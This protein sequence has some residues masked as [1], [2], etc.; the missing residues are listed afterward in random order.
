VRLLALIYLTLLLTLATLP[1][2]LAA[3]DWRDRCAAVPERANV[4]VF[5]PSPLDSIA[6]W[7]LPRWTPHLMIV[8]VVGLE[9][10][11]AEPNARVDSLERELRAF[12]QQD[13]AGFRTLMLAALRAGGQRSVPE[14]VADEAAV[15]YRQADGRAGPVL[16]ALGGAASDT[17]LLPL[18]AINSTLSGAE[19]DAI[20][21]IACDVALPLI[22]ARAAGVISPGWE[23]HARLEWVDR[24]E[25]ILRHAERLV[26]G[27]RRAVVEGLVAGVQPSAP[28]LDPKAFKGH[29]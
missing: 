6:I 13:S 28:P 11:V 2:P 8:R 9:D 20:A 4:G 23:S 26:Q 12:A 18:S 1:T 10:G 24:T 3:Q 29:L 16:T 7:V 25:R 15:W 27:S 17:W 22:A 19:A 5:P 21:R 14:L